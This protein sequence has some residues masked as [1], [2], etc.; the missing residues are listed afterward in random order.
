MK[1]QAEPDTTTK[2]VARPRTIAGGMAVTARIRQETRPNKLE[3]DPTVWILEDGQGGCLEIWPALGFNAYR[4]AVGDT[5]ILYRDP[6]FFDE[7][8]P[9]RSGIPILFPFPNRIKDG[10]FTWEGKDYVLAKNDSTGKNAIHGFANTRTW[11][12]IDQGTRDNEAWITGEFLSSR[13][14]AD[15]SHL[16][17]ADY[18]L[19]V[20]VRLRANTLELHANVHNP[21]KNGLPWG[22]GYHPYFRL[23]PFG[24]ESA[25][26][27]VPV[28][29][30][31]LLDESLP[32]GETQPASGDR[33]LQTRL[34]L[35]NRVFDD[36]YGNITSKPS[37]DVRF[38]GLIA[39]SNL[40]PTRLLLG[41]SNEFREMVI[42]TP[43]HRQAICVEPYTCVTDAI[44][45]QARGIDA[46]WKVLAP[47]ENTHLKVELSFHP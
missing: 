13:D 28:A 37:R 22:L 47:G 29:T 15:V 44:H 1:F 35:G 41:Q 6:K 9:S 20:M 18:R 45:L 23:E 5:E 43:P 2:L 16:W 8:K 38:G 4:W 30:R 3:R 39:K 27:E 32:T 14:A 7:L 10:T 11:R 19:R 26:L 36:V 12:I 46:G 21:S 40:L 42:F 17:P 33:V 24:G 34:P 25:L 31:W